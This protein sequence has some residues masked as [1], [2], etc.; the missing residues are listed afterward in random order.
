MLLAGILALCMLP[1]V[2]LPGT[3][4]GAWALPQ[5]SSANS[6]QNSTPDTNTP[7]SSVQQTA[8]DSQKETEKSGTKAA[9]KKPKKSDKKSDTQG[10]NQEAN[11]E[12]K[13]KVVSRGGTDEPTAQI[14]PSMT[15]EQI[16]KTRASTAKLLS[17]TEINLQKL[18]ARKL[19][20]DEQETVDQIRKFVEQSRQADREDDVQ[21]A[22]SLANKAKL[23]SDALVKE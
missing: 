2:L 10:A 12:P 11:P 16:T 13:K 14:S 22:A 1:A 7:P 17:Q 15:E 20:K 8:P 18:S 21:S 23:L 6:T 19:S 9:K 5:S 3:S 4:G